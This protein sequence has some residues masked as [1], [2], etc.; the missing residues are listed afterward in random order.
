MME[1]YHTR[2]VFVDLNTNSIPLD[3]V[4]RLQVR[5][6]ALQIHLRTIYS[7]SQLSLEFGC[8]TRCDNRVRKPYCR[9]VALVRLTEMSSMFKHKVFLSRV[10][11]HWM[12]S[13]D[14]QVL[15]DTP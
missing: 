10:T 3:I 6:S 11:H 4:L 14:E 5:R 1:E 9:T 8:R 15:T 7:L 12:I 2:K 13:F